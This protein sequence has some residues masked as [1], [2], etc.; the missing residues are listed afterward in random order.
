MRNN[1]ATESVFREPVQIVKNASIL[2]LRRG[3]VI[4]LVAHRTGTGRHGVSSVPALNPAAVEGSVGLVAVWAGSVTDGIVREAARIA[5]NATINAARRTAHS[6]SGVRGASVPRPA[7]VALSPVTERARVR[8][9]EERVVIPM[10]HCTRNVHVGK[11]AAPR[12]AHSASGVRGENVP[13][14][15]VTALSLVTERARVRLVEERVV[16]HMHPSTRNVHAGKSAALW[17]AIGVRGVSTVPALKHAAVEGSVGLVAVLARSV[18]DNLVKGR[19]RNAVNATINAARRTAHS[20][21]GVRGASVPRPAVVAFSPVTERASIKLAA[22][23]VVTLMHPSMKN[24]HAGKSVVQWT[25]V[26]AAGATLANV[27]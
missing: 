6:A 14:R 16:I 8:L 19:A 4:C 5:A 9:V 25:V 18:T 27:P 21:S 17:T 11:N 10:H 22:E 1:I 12:T 3:A 7:V 15:A 13:R 26:G 2:P 24:V 23:R 20:A